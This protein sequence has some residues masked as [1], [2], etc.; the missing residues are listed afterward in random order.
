MSNGCRFRSQPPVVSAT[1]AAIT[2]AAQ[3]IDLGG[4]SACAFHNPFL[5]DFEE[6]VAGTKYKAGPS[7]RSVSNRMGRS[8]DREKYWQVCQ[9]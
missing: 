7:Q 4:S 2:Q 5:D 3:P 6:A 1:A 9:K 8:N